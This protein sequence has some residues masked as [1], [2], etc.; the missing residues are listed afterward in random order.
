MWDLMRLLEYSLTGG[1]VQLHDGARDEPPRAAA[2]AA[3]GAGGPSAPVQRD[4]VEEGQ[5]REAVLHPVL[6][7]ASRVCRCARACV[8]RRGWFWG[9]R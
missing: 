4:D 3:V 7:L 9:V 5:A 6:F 1:P 2:A 8:V